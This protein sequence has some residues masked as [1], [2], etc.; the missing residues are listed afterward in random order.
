MIDLINEYS[1]DVIKY[2]NE[3]QNI[4]SDKYGFCMR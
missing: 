4:W 3:F 1:D 2:I